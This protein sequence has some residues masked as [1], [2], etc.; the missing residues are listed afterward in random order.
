MRVFRYFSHHS[1]VAINTL[2]T[3]ILTMVL[4]IKNIQRLS[5]I[6]HYVECEVI[7]E[8]VP[9]KGAEIPFFDNVKF[10]PLEGVR[11]G[12]YTRQVNIIIVLQIS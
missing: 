11:N 6:G 9:K 1:K 8:Q 5:L 3:V 12:S 10:T 4:S 2:D 7:L